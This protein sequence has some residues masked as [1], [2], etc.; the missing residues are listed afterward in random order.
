MKKLIL[1]VILLCVGVYLFDLYNP[2]GIKL[3]EEDVSYKKEVPVEPKKPIEKKPLTAQDFFL[4]GEGNLKANN[5]KTAILNFSRALELDPSYAEAY[6]ERALAK[7][8]TGDFEGSKQDYEKYIEMI[9][10]Q[11]KE[12]NEEERKELKKLIAETNKKVVNKKYDE[13]IVD[14]SNIID[15]YSKYPDGY[16]AR[17]DVYFILKKY[18]Q[19]LNDYKRALVL[20]N[21]TFALYLKLANTEYELELYKDSIKDYL[22]LLKSNSKYEYAYYKL[23]GAYIFDEDFNAALKILNDYIKIS[24]TQHIKTTDYDKWIG[25]LNKYSENETIRDLKSDLKKLKFI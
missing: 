15:S 20:G 24:S 11:N 4:K 12:G 16:I 2:F 18:E 19:A 14:L 3:F 8:N 23:I 6:K 9:E 1:L 7:D 22:T 5:Y 25:V 17:A 21:N 10:I 13:A